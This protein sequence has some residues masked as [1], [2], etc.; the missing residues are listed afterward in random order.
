[1]KKEAS[2]NQDTSLSRCRTFMSPVFIDS[3]LWKERFSPE[4]PRLHSYRSTHHRHPM[5][6]DFH[7]RPQRFHPEPIM[8]FS[9]NAVSASPHLLPSP[10][11]P[12]IVRR[13]E[14]IV[15]V[16]LMCT[17]HLASTQETTSSRSFPL[18]DAELHS[19][20]FQSQSFLCVRSS[21]SDQTPAKSL[22]RRRAN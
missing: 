21:E 18:H 15:S 1:M 12:I 20:S 14:E 2:R 22:R 19:N 6:N 16:C 10:S 7:P 9:S 4:P 5:S 13:G 8:T 3:Q 17:S 11:Q